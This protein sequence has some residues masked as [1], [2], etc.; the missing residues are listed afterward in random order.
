MVNSGSCGCLDKSPCTGQ[1]HGGAT[2]GDD[3]D[4]AIAGAEAAYGLAKA[5]AHLTWTT[6]VVGRETTFLTEEATGRK[7]LIA[8]VDGV[9]PG[10]AELDKTYTV[11]LAGYAATAAGDDAADLAQ[12]WNDAESAKSDRYYDQSSAWA[13]FRSAGYADQATAV[14][15]LAAT[16]D[17]PW[18]HFQADLYAAKRDRWNSVTPDGAIP[19]AYHVPLRN[20]S[21]WT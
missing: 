11:N 3:Y 18:A 4:T 17:V 7:E 1:Y 12:F 2:A 10:L 13:D 20:F 6:D 5:E 14:A 21:H 16:I 8:G 15:T 9:S 19:T